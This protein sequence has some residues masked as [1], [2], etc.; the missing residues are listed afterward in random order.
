MKPG[1]A[2]VAVGDNE[3]LEGLSTYLESITPSL[4]V[5]SII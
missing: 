5:Q 4:V 3:S 1:V 2:P